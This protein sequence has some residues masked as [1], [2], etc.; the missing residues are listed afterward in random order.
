MNVW[1]SR[2]GVN[3]WAAYFDTRQIPVMASSRHRM[4][5]LE[6]TKRELLSP[7]ELAEVVADDPLLCL[8]YLREAERTR[9]HRLENEITTVLAAVLHLGVD[10]CRRLLLSGDVIDHGQP[11]L[12]DAVTR[13]ATAARLAARWAEA[14]MVINPD[15]LAMAALLAESGEL[16]LWAHEPDLAQAAHD[17]LAAGLAKSGLQAQMQ[18]CKF[19]FRQLTGRC[20]EVWNLPTFL[21]LIVR[22]AES[23]RAQFVRLCTSVARQLACE[24]GDTAALA[25]DIVRVVELVPSLSLDGMVEGLSELSIERR[26]ELLD[27]AKA[28]QA[29][30][31]IKVS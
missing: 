9:S 30:R 11:G 4:L 22:G 3:Q 6:A 8:K 27:F 5:R 15:E 19:E 20:A 26:I 14:G 25:H 13:S 18:T 21:R 12:L 2:W 1:R 17:E 28:L 31:R 23:R 16:L 24:P 10:T 7:R 29:E